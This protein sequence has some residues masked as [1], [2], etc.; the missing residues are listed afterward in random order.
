M[1]LNGTRFLRFLDYTYD[2]GTNICVGKGRE[3]ERKSGES[4]GRE[5]EE[6][7]RSSEER[8]FRTGKAG[9]GTL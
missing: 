5:Q 1:L 4:A 8:S 7:G 2:L 6:G 9:G 3:R